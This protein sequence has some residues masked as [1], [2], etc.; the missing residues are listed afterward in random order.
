MKR[1]CTWRH[2]RAK[3]AG[4]RLTFN[5]PS[6]T[7]LSCD[8]LWVSKSCTSEITH[9]VRIGRSRWSTSFSFLFFFFFSFSFFNFSKPLFSRLCL[10]RSMDFAKLKRM[11]CYWIHQVRDVWC[12][13]FLF[14]W[15]CFTLEFSV[16]N[17]YAIITRGSSNTQCFLIV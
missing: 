12:W 5:P 9:V 1:G 3:L 13:V 16:N 15:K 17:L 6:R 7:C 8:S 4:C 2:W 10:N 14:F 11:L